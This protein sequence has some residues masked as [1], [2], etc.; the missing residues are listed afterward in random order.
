MV[1]SA[2]G[3]APVAALLRA[4]RLSILFSVMQVAYELGFRI[5]IP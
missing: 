5:K 4:S 3:I 1:T 2:S